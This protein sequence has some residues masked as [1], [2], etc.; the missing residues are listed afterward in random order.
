MRDKPDLVSAPAQ[1][2]E[3]QGNDALDTAVM[4]RRYG[5]KRV[6]R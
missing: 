6:H 4:R 5:Q 3:Q 1:L 2:D